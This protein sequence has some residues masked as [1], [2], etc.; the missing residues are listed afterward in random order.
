MKAN[1]SIPP[2]ILLISDIVKKRRGIIE[3]KNSIDGSFLNVPQP[4]TRG[5]I[6]AGIAITRPRFAMFEP[7]KLPID[8]PILPDVIAEKD[9]ASSGRLV[10][11]ESRINPITSSPSFVI[12]ASLTE[13]FITIWLALA[14][15]M[16]D[17]MNM[18]S[19][20][21]ML[22][23]IPFTKG[24]VERAVKIFISINLISI[25]IDKLFLSGFLSFFLK[26]FSTNRNN[27]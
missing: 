22:S 25:L 4:I 15:I 10:A 2:I 6:I 24:N 27:F 21:R 8:M 18:R 23:E 1:I 9:T 11:T 26:L 16:T 13:F 12:R 3:H 5:V 17:I 14:R 19:W 20:Y 7:S